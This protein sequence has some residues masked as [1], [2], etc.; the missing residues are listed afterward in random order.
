MTSFINRV[1]TIAT[2]Q[3]QLPHVQL[4]AVW[5][6]LFGR[7]PYIDYFRV[8]ACEQTSSQVARDEG[9]TAKHH[10]REFVDPVWKEKL[11]HKSTD[12]YLT[13]RPFKFV[14]PKVNSPANPIVVLICG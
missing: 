5:D 10:Q 14:L 2:I 13:F 7:V 11:L 1:M 6:G 4:M 12:K 9:S 8:N 3:F